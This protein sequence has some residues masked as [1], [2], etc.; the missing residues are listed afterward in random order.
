MVFSSGS[1]RSED[2]SAVFLIVGYIV[3]GRDCHARIR[4]NKSHRFGAALH[5]EHRR[6]YYLRV[7]VGE[8]LILACT[9][10]YIYGG[11]RIRIGRVILGYEHILRRLGLTLG[12]LC[13]LGT[14]CF[15]ALYR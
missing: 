10:M 3:E 7:F 14:F 11:I 2:V 4:I 12:A 8:Q 13:L 15:G 6:P 5:R 1:S 9:Q